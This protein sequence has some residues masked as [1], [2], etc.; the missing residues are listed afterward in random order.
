LVLIPL[1]LQAMLWSAIRP[2]LATSSIIIYL[3][4]SSM[5]AALTYAAAVM[6]AKP[7]SLAVQTIQTSGLIAVFITPL[8]FFVINQ[9]LWPMPLGLLV[10]GCIV[11]YHVRMIKQ[12]YRE[13]A[14]GLILASVWWLMWFYGV[15]A[16]QAYSHA[17]VALLAVYAYWRHQR[18]EETICDQYLGAML[19]AATIPLVIQ[20]L[21]GQA[22]GL[23]GWWLL[24]EEIGFMIIGMAIGK[25][26]LTRWG[27]Y[28]AVAAV[29]Y[30]LRNLGWAALTVLALFLIGL[31]VAKI[32]KYQEK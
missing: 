11:Y 28:I 9:T 23:Y 21:G 7:T 27:L 2:E 13:L 8:T 10:A 15:T 20:A 5:L 29:L 30:Q 19:T 6:R 3:I 14:G 17:L 25:R 22:G 32:L 26:F 1:L 24:L 4:L 18:S 16:A 12:S 31:A